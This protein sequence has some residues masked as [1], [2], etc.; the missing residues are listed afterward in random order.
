M[1][2]SERYYLAD[3]VFVAAV[4]GDT[5][6]LRELDA[7]LELPVYPPYLGRRSCPPAQPLRLALHMDGRLE[8][9]LAQEPWQASAW[10]RR[11]RR[12]H[13]TVAL[14]VL[15]EAAPDEDTWDT[16]RDQPLS[17]STEHRRHALRPVIT[18]TVRIPNPDARPSNAAAPAHDPF[19]AL[20]EEETG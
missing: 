9:V 14:S 5:V 15:R 19:A 18:E 7:A 1:P 17:F 11:Q 12:Q 16:L 20:D 4:E 13:E 10:Y 2:V 8:Q 6:L 3:A